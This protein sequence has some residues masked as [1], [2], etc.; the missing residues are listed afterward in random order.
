MT[1]RLTP[2]DRVKELGDASVPFEFDVHA[3]IQ[4]D[5]APALEKELHK[6]FM[7]MQVNKVNPRKEFFKVSLADIKSAIDTMNHTVKWTL[8]AEARQFRESQTIELE[9]KNDIQKKLEWEK[10][11]MQIEASTV[12]ITEEIE[13]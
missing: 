4:C 1:R 3:M 11:Q 6:K 9:I 5:N 2:E 13:A 10:H 12:E 7:H 8:T